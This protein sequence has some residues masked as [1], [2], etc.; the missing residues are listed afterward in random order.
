MTMLR[1]AI[2]ML[3]AAC[4]C[5]FSPLVAA[6]AFEPI[7]PA[8]QGSKTISC[9][10]SPSAT[11]LAT[12]GAGGP[13]QLELQNGGSAVIFVEV[14]RSSVT[15]ATTTGYPI[16]AGQSKV[17]SVGPE[18]TH[19]ACVVASSTHTLYVTVGRGN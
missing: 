17:I 15:A 13:R 16:L 8:F 6:Q 3:V 1:A 18:T 2:A 11:A 10:S 4:L 7:A 12:A 19:I 9:T 5:L 14:G